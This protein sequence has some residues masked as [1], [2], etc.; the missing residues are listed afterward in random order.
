MVFTTLNPYIF[1]PQ[2]STLDCDRCRGQIS[3]RILDPIAKDI[4]ERG[5]RVL[6]STSL[7]DLV[8]SG[9][10]INS[11]VVRGGDGLNQTMPADAVVVAGFESPP[12]LPP[13]AFQGNSLEM[14]W[15]LM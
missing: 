8:K 11:V 7:I 15:F 2:P 12:H 10:S 5:G 13:R 4:E 6:S 3:D 9:D 14:P 1:E